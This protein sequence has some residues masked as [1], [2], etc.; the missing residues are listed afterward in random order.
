MNI[1]Y[2][3]QLFFQGARGKTVIRLLKFSLNWWR[4]LPCQLAYA[5][6]RNKSLV[7]S[8]FGSYGNI[9]RTLVFAKH[10]R[11]L[12]YHRMGRSS[13]LYSWLLPGERSLK[14]PFSCKLGM[15]AHFVHND[16]CHLN[17]GCIGENFTCY[18]HVVIGTK[19]LRHNGKPTIG[20]NVTIGTGAVVVGEIRIGNNV[21]IGANAF[22][23]QD[24]PDNARVV[25]NATVI[26][27]Q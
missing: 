20:N 8:D 26:T 14:L 12:F 25:S 24:I 2:Q 7:R 27:R 21:A 1:I 22:V 19:S 16:C 9:V 13:V 3:E 6:S 18:P 5:I 17:A 10:N 11:N 23:C 15:H 4:T